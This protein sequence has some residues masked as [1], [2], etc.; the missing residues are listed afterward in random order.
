MNDELICWKCGEG[1]VDVLFPF[2]RRE[3]CPAC[4]ADQH[5]CKLC[6]FYDPGSAEACAE[7]RSESVSDKETANFCD[8]FSP[9]P[10]AYVGKNR[11]AQ[12]A[13]EDELAAL[14]GQE[15]AGE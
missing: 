14:F 13:A 15:A 8:Y 1:L 4:G 6:K 5:V 10:N 11:P 2:S 3:E 12:A 7:E 9:T